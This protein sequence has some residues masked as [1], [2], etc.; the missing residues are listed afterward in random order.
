MSA[1]GALIPEIR[2]IRVHNRD[3]VTTWWSSPMPSSHFLRIQIRYL[4]PDSFIVRRASI[5]YTNVLSLQL[6]IRPQNTSY[7]PASILVMSGC[8]YSNMYIGVEG[9]VRR[10]VIGWKGRSRPYRG[11]A[12][13]PTIAWGKLCGGSGQTS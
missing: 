13:G 1:G 11:C 6:E 3:L 9:A 5:F 2:L 10:T 8:D 7:V 12:S 4:S